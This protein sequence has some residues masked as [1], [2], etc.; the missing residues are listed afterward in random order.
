[1]FDRITILHL[2]RKL[3]KVIRDALLANDRVLIYGER[4]RL[5]AQLREIIR[6]ALTACK[7]PK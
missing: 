6:P 5:R 3:A 1:M 7:G 4:N 2:A